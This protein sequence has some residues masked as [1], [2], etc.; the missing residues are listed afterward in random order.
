LVGVAVNVTLVPELIVPE[1]LAAILALAATERLTVIVIEFDVAGE[2]VAH[3]AVDVI[4][5]V[6]IL[7]LAKDDEVYIALVA[8]EIAVP[9]FFHW[10]VGE[11]PPLVGVA[12][13]V[14]LVPEHIAPEVLAAILTL[15]GKLEFTVIVI[16]LE[17]AGEP[18]TQEALLVIIQVIL[19]LLTKDDEAYIEL[20]APEIAIPFFCH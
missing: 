13:K 2:P 12:V 19:S 9:L 16:R 6:I 10:Y 17:V 18:L 7:P 3:V 14:T 15:A 20:I 4:T 11:L 5:Q 8:P 1:G